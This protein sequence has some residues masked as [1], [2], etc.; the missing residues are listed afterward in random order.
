MLTLFDSFLH[1]HTHTHKHTHAR[2]HTHTVSPSLRAVKL[3]NASP[4]IAG[5]FV[6]PDAT[7]VGKVTIGAQSSV[8][9]GATL[10]GDVSSITVGENVTIGDRVMVHCSSFPRELPTK[11]ENNVVVGAGAILHGC[12]VCEGAV[13]GEGAQVMDGAVV[14]R[15]AVV[16]PGAVVSP[17]KV[18]AA[19][20]LFAGVPAT[21]VRALT[22]EEIAAQTLL[23]QENA[24]LAAV[25]AEEQGKSWQAIESEELL[26]EQV[27]E[28]NT[29]YYRRV[30]EQELQQKAGEVENHTVPGRIFDSAISA[31]THP[32][33]VDK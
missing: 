21:L 9:Y 12:T 10:R 19:K 31:R 33:S 1:T 26:R 16:A 27:Q 3:R 8:W 5:A 32:L 28:R 2:T 18:V 15:H 24:T 11:I 30:D 20:T 6:A 17:G 25:H 7:L 13:I 23:V 29:E 14:E 22:A 4:S